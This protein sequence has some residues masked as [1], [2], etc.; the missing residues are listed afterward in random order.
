M[1]NLIDPAAVL[2]G[3][4]DGIL[5][6]DTDGTIRFVNAPAEDLLGQRADAG[7]RVA[8]P[9]RAD[10]DGVA[11]LIHDLSVDRRGG[12]GRDAEGQSHKSSRASVL[13]QLV[14]YN[15]R[16]GVVK[17]PAASPLPRS[18]RPR[19]GRRPRRAESTQRLTSSW[20]GV[21]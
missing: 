6:L 16:P 1:D 10:G 11:D 14:Q 5:V 17:S 4:P 18:R 3:S 21:E 9:L 13:L 19:R 15:T 7:Q 20:R 2:A 8:G 12:A